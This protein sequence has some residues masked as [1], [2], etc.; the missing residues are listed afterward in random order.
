M[1]CSDI[2]GLV[3][4]SM[5]GIDGILGSVDVVLVHKGLWEIN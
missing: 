3:E 5:I 4:F 1:E 2:K